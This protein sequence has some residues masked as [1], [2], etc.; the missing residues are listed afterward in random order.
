MDTLF[1]AKMFPDHH[2]READRIIL[3]ILEESTLNDDNSEDDTDDDQ[4]EPFVIDPRMVKLV[5][6]FI[7]GSTAFSAENKLVLLQIKAQESNFCG[8]FISYTRQYLSVRYAISGNTQ[9]V[10]ERV[11]FLLHNWNFICI[12][13]TTVST[14]YS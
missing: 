6:H 11:K 3:R 14:L 4:H 9:Q 10:R 1:S 2:N 8:R 5:G 12:D 13:A 7:K